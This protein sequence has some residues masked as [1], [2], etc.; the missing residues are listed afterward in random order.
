M[1]NR[2]IYRKILE[3]EFRKTIGKPTEYL[4]V[5]FHDDETIHVYTGLRKAIKHY[6]MEIGSD[7]DDF[8]FYDSR[9][10]GKTYVIRFPMPDD[11]L[12]LIWEGMSEEEIQ[13]NL[14]KSHES[15]VRLG[16]RRCYGLED[17]RAMAKHIDEVVNE[18]V[19]KREEK[20]SE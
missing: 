5:E 12:R 2:E 13:E 11:W 7:D 10:K 3:R 1:T 18:A 6:I 15:S 20:A 16:Y 4:R 8:A 19:R 14:K 9:D 17:C